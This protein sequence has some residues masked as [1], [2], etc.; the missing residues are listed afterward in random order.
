MLQITRVEMTMKLKYTFPELDD[1]I[2]DEVLKKFRPVTL[3]VWQMA[4]VRLFIEN[5]IL[6]FITRERSKGKRSRLCLPTV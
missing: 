4:D 2:L 1:D 6:Y 3:T 5:E